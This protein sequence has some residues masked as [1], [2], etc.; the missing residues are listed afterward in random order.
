MR[1]KKKFFVFIA[2]KKKWKN[3][4]I[5]NREDG[6]ERLYDLQTGGS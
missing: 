2:K 1:I 6:K 3:E 4:I 5:C